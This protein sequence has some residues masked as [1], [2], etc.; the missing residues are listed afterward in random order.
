MR[1]RRKRVQGEHIGRRAH[2]ARGRC[3]DALQ[4]DLE[5]GAG[6]EVGDDALQRFEAR[7]EHF[8]AELVVLGELLG[9]VYDIPTHAERA[10]GRALADARFLDDLAEVEAEHV[11]DDA[12][13]SAREVAVLGERL[14]PFFEVLLAQ[15]FGRSELLRRHREDRRE[16]AGQLLES[17]EEHGGRLE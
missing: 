2:R 16:V 14:E 8:G 15:P 10:R 13:Q 5:V 3:N 9:C 12:Q 17:V 7:F 11:R 4:H 6:H 1:G